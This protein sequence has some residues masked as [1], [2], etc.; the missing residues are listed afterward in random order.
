[1][2]PFTLQTPTHHPSLYFSPSN[3]HMMTHTRTD[4]LTHA[5]L[6]ACVDV[7]KSGINMRGSVGKL[8]FRRKR[9]GQVCSELKYTPLKPGDEQRTRRTAAQSRRPSFHSAGG[10]S[11]S[12]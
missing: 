6:P 4:E 10:E 3:A 5:H 12:K 2:F 8:V 9:T 7:N 11:T 1:M